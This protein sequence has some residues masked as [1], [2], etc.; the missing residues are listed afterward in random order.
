MK[1]QY[2][3][4][5]IAGWTPDRLHR[6]AL[7]GPGAGQEEAAMT[8]GKQ[9]RRAGDGAG[10]PPPSVTLEYERGRCRYR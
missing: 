4:P 8:I 1:A 10:T 3:P 5:G 7:V 9:V 2:P 6:R